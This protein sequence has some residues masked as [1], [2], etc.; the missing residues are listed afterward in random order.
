VFGGPGFQ[1]MQSVVSTDDSLVAVGYDGLGNDQD[2][3]VW[4]SVDGIVW[5]RVPVIEGATGLTGNQAMLGI[6]QTEEGLVAVG[7]DGLSAAVWTS[8]DGHAWDRTP[9][10]EAFGGE[11]NQ[12][13]VS[14]TT[15]G[16]TLV[17]IGWDGLDA[18]AWVSTDGT[19]WSRAPVGAGAHPREG[20]RLLT[21]A[22][23]FG[24]DFVGVGWGMNGIDLDA[25]A[26][27]WKDSQVGT[28]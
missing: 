28:G 7:Y 11:V 1:L 14:V 19:T 24:A 12:G 10:T 21:S 18:A 25:K 16:P 13:M 5:A 26:W 9:S 27:V 22:I 20:S 4:T 3:V 15:N 23:H 17:A 2:A 6:T 8:I